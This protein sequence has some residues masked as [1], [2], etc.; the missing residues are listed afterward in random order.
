MANLG[1]TVGWDDVTIVGK[2]GPKAGTSLK[3]QADVLAAQKKGL[4]VDTEKKCK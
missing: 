3:S 2:R 4:Q 1:G